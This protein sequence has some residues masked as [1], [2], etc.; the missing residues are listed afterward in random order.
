MPEVWLKYVRWDVIEG[1][2]ARVLSDRGDPSESFPYAFAS[3]EGSF[4]RITGGVLWLVTSPRFDEYR[5]PPSL[6]ARLDVVDV[7]RGDSR[8]ARELDPEVQRHG[9]WVARAERRLGAYLPVNNALHALQRLRF[10]GTPDRLPDLGVPARVRGP[11][12]LRP[13]AD[14]PGR[15][16]QHRVVAEESVPV[17]EDYAG[18][19]RSGR[20]VFLSYRWSDFAEDPGWV[21]ALADALSSRLVSCWWDRWDV[22]QDQPQLYPERILT[23]ILNDAIRQS[24][25]FVALMRPGYLEA[26]RAQSPATWARREWDLAGRQDP[27]RPQDDLSRMAVSFGDPRCIGDWIDPG[28]DDVVTVPRDA[29]PAQVADRIVDLLPPVQVELEW[30]R[31]RAVDPPDEGWSPKR[32]PFGIALPDHATRPADPMHRRGP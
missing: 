25:W 1:W 13:Y 27:Q 30:H 15:F 26:C 4:P 10:R 31:R 12:D 28:V 2:R 11:A 19:V 8:E 24:A 32:L 22:P 6:V 23:A 20:R 21:M 18:A 7:V 5:L 3:R 16:Q 29:S 9:G 14:I 17:L